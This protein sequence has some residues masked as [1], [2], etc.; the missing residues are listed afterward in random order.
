[1]KTQIK[2]CLMIN[3]ST[4]DLM[5]HIDIPNFIIA[6]NILAD[7]GSIIKDL[8]L[9]GKKL[10][11]VHGER[12]FKPIAR[13]LNKNL[14]SGKMLRAFSNSITEVKRL[15]VEINRTRVD[16][17]IG[18][19]GGKVLDPAKLASSNAGKSFI[20]IPT[21]LSHDGIA[22]PVAV[23]DYGNEVKSIYAHMPFGVIID[24]GIIKQSPIQNI[25]AGIGD[26]LS[27]ISAAE[28]WL[29]AEQY[30]KFKIDYFALLLAKIPALHLLKNDYRDLKDEDLLKDLAEGLVLSGIAMSITGNSRPASGAEHL[31]SHG[32]DE[33]LKNREL[34]GIQCGIAT[35]FAMGLRG[36][37]EWQRIKKFYKKLKLPQRPE[38]IGITK[39]LFLKAVK[40]APKT[41]TNRFTIL[42]IIGKNKK[43]LFEIYDEVYG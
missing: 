15:E 13:K 30:G 18:I 3:D 7:F 28:D 40:I 29:L 11:I 16:F 39:D 20:S 37:N 21:T 17:V 27:N 32:L 24:V 4:I 26:L 34:H 35:I 23:I 41:R 25:G 43:L 2:K 22:S 9:E 33:L 5:R 6:K 1:M 31:I 8:G 36:S 14:K 42:N 38:D 19:G 10:L 12:S